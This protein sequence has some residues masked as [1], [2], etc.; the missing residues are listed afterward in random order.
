MKAC[1]LNEELEIVT[2]TKRT[3]LYISK[4]W[5]SSHQT[6][7]ESDASKSIT[8]YLGTHSPQ[9]TNNSHVMQES[10]PTSN[11]LGVDFGTHIFLGPNMLVFRTQT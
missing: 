3:H 1:K 10:T 11:R 5:W 7:L 6:P 2:K 8:I 4:P 9:G